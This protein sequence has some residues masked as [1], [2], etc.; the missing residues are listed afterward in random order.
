MASSSTA[1][2]KISRPRFYSYLF[3]TYL[4]G[5]VV[6]LSDPAQLTDKNF[7][8]FLAFFVLPCNLFLYGANDIFDTETDLK[9]PKKISHEH[10]LKKSEKLPLILSVVSV[11]VLTLSLTLFRTPLQSGLLIVFLLLSFFYSAPPLR[12]KALPFLDAYSNVLYALPGFFGYALFTNSFPSLAIVVLAFTWNAGMHALSA[13]PDIAVDRAARIT[14]TAVYLGTRKT[15]FFILAN[16]SISSLLSIWLLGPWG[17]VSLIYPALC[18]YLLVTQRPAISIY[19][20]FPYITTTVG[21]TTFWYIFISRF[22]WEHI[23]Q[24]AQSLL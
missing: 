4:L 24:S 13:I 8:F 1:L 18:I 12:F 9:N 6:G 14:T 7:L 10:K 3:G 19:W 15:L 22:G 16:W 5:A 17:L 2:L 11:A 21:F 23:W 20:F